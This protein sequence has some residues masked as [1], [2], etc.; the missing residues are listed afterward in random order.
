ME[1]E[2]GYELSFMIRNTNKSNNVVGTF[3]TTEFICQNDSFRIFLTDYT[4]CCECDQGDYHLY[5]NF[6]VTI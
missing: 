6:M 3:M 2:T 5:T 4:Y 1:S